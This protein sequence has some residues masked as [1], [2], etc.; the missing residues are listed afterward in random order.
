MD[1]DAEGRLAALKDGSARP[2][3][4]ARRSLRPPRPQRARAPSQREHR[5]PIRER[6]APMR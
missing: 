3:T 4:S 6:F 5:L 2:A 1:A